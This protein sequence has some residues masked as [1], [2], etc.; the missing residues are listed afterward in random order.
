MVSALLPRRR[1]RTADL[2]LVLHLRQGL[3]LI[4]AE[5]LGDHACPQRKDR[6]SVD[7][8]GFHVVTLR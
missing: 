1:L 8:D 2:Q 7:G 3:V 6:R 4:E 5:A